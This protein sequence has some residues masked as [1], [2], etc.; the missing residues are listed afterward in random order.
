VIVQ[1]TVKE[2]PGTEFAKSIRIQTNTRFRGKIKVSVNID[3]SASV[4]KAQVWIAKQ[5]LG[6]AIQTSVATGL[7]AVIASD[8]SA[9]LASLEVQATA[10]AD[11]AITDTLSKLPVPANVLSE[12]FF[13]AVEPTLNTIIEQGIAEGYVEALTDVVGEAQAAVVLAAQGMSGALSSVST[14]PS[15]SAA[16]ESALSANEAPAAQTVGA[17]LVSPPVLPVVDGQSA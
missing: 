12:A 16:N 7:R 3:I 15:P 8:P 14:P 9:T 10:L 2:P 17:A 5:T 4:Q 1:G 6:A 13:T 11:N